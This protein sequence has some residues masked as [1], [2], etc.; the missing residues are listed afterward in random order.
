MMVIPSMIFP[1][2]D[3]NKLMSD[4]E[5]KEFY[6]T[7]GYEGEDTSTSTYPKGVKIDSFAKIFLDFHS[8]VYRY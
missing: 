1:D 4:E 5:K 7:I 8:L 2:F 6:R 3:L